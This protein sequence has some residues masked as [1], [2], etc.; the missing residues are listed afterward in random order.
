M[1]DA[2]QLSG[3]LELPINSKLIVA[4]NA[5]DFEKSIPGA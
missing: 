3:I 2:Y 5:L 4:V 1:Q